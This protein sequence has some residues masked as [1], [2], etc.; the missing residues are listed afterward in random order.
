METYSAVVRKI[1]QTKK[2]L[3]KLNKIDLRFYQF[4]L[5]VA[6]KIDFH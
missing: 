3:G 1:L 2:V 4:V 6:R 5:F